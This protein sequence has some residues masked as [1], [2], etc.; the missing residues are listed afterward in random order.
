MAHFACHGNADT[1]IGTLLLSGLSLGNGTKLTP[2]QLHSYR[3]EHAEL[4]FL[5]ACSTAEPHPDLPDESLHL[6][7]AFQLAGFRSVIGTLWVTSDSPR[8]AQAVYSAL[9]AGGTRPPDTSA[10]VIVLNDTLRGIRDAF[11]AVPT[12]W[13]AHLH[14]GA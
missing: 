6:A 5:S 8:I 3:L 1:S 13:A 9:T 12:R 4:A 14:V 7:S 11:P 10:A 2:A